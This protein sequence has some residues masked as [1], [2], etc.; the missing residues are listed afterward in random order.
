M[1]DRDYE[2]VHEGLKIRTGPV[3]GPLGTSVLNALSRDILTSESTQSVRTSSIAFNKAGRV[4]YPKFQCTVAGG[5]A[6]PTYENVM[7]CRIP[8]S[9]PDCNR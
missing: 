3:G 4:K 7:A 6:V 1:R 2:V 5:K 8:S 9:S